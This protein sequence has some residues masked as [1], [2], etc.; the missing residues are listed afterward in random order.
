MKPKMT[1]VHYPSPLCY[2]GITLVSRRVINKASKSQHI[3][4][5]L[6]TAKKKKSSVWTTTSKL[7]N[8]PIPTHF[9]GGQAGENKLAMEKIGSTYISCNN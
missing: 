5:L 4:G 8:Q 2:K 6:I 3:P 7:P 1:R 9:Q